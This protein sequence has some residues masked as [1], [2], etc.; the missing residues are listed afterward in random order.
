VD[1][2]DKGYVPSSEISGG[3][4]DDESVRLHEVCPAVGAVPF[5]SEPFF[6]DNEA[7]DQEFL[8]GA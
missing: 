5:A 8:H 7:A 6:V 2:S 4:V 3:G 1:L